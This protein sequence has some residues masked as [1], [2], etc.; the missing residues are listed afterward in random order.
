L[1]KAWFLTLLIGISGC[2]GGSSSTPLPPA[3]PVLAGNFQMT[4]QSQAVPGNQTIVGGPL[5]TDSS[6]HVTGTLHIFDAQTSC[7][8]IF[9]DALFAGTVNA[10]GQLAASANVAGQ[11]ISVKGQVSTDGKTITSGTYA[12]VGGCAGGDHGTLSGSQV[13]PYTGTY[14]GSFT[15]PDPGGLLFLNISL[16]LTQPTAADQHGLFEFP[17][18]AATFIFPQTTCGFTSATLQTGSTVSIA[19]GLFFQVTMAANDGLST[20]V[21][22]GIAS[23]DTTKKIV[24]TISVTGTGFCGGKSTPGFIARP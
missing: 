16:P 4:T 7:F 8:N 10:Q 11:A 13:Q 15:L 18:S 5:T 22:T 19:S 17:A 24:G 12:V 2:G 1:A 21:F 14:A 9:D 3:P 6:G 23:D 20:V